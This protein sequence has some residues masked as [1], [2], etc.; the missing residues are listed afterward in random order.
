MEKAQPGWSEHR[1]LD[2]G[3]QGQTG[4]LCEAMQGLGSQA[5]EWAHAALHLMMDLDP[6][7]GRGLCL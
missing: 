7:E 6:R 3:L 2:S 4:E 1:G 5:R